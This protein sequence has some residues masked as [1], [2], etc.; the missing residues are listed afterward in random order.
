MKLLLNVV[1]PLGLAFVAGVINYAV[2]SRTT[3]TQSY[4]E[5]A[6]PL[7]P[8]EAF[9]MP[10][11]RQVKVAAK[12]PGAIP[13]EERHVLATLKAPRAIESGDWVMLSDVVPLAESGIQLKSAEVALNVSL[14]GIVIEPKLLKIGQPLG[15]VIRKAEEGE[16]ADGAVTKVS[17]S[18]EYQIVGPF[19]LVTLGEFSAN[20]LE[21]NEDNNARV[22]KT[23]SVAVPS[24]DGK[25]LDAES[26][27]LARAIEQSR[28]TAIVLYPAKVTKPAAP[29][30]KTEKPET[31]NT[32]K[33]TKTTEASNE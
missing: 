4:I 18:T 3:P 10:L 29:S 24:V 2:L 19:R 27:A 9:K 21:D 6:E 13:W 22:P 26:Q 30:A 14:E 17:D 32:T 7:K 12:V 11:L 31:T 28:I 25:S 8:G 23:I 15:F 33:Q 1:L 16:P 5:I 20:E